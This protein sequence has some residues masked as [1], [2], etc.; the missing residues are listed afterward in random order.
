MITINL[1][2]QVGRV[3]K[4]SGLWQPLS[5]ARWV[6]LILKLLNCLPSSKCL[7]E[8]KTQVQLSVV[9][10]IHFHAGPFALLPVFTNDLK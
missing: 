5:V 9:Y 3:E 1:I 8:R 7:E 4:E 10:S 2:L 6:L